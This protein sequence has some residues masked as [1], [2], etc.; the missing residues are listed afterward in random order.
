MSEVVHLLGGPGTVAYA[1]FPPS[2]LSF[3]RSHRAGNAL[4]SSAQKHS[5]FLWSS[6][7]WWMC[8]HVCLMMDL[9]SDSGNLSC[10]SSIINLILWI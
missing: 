6:L 7:L 2:K 8:F 3:G 9:G 4:V 1:L 5:S 10:I